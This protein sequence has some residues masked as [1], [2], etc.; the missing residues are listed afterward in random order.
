MPDKVLDRGANLRG[1]FLQESTVCR[2]GGWC[3]W[4]PSSKFLN[5]SFSSLSSYRNYRTAPC[6]AIRGNSISVDS[7]LRPLLVCCSGL[8]SLRHF[9][10]WYFRIQDFRVSI[11]QNKNTDFRTLCASIPQWPPNQFKTVPDSRLEVAGERDIYIYICIRMYVYIYIYI[12]IYIYT[13]YTHICISLSLSLYIYI[14]IYTLN[15]EIHM[16]CLNEESGRIVLTIR[17]V[18]LLRVSISEGLTQADS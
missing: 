12:H 5:S 1:F 4:K 9:R 6:R 8:E 10:R 18:R 17:P 7:T 16:S 11:W 2:K 3:G 13:Y 15:Y 14:Y